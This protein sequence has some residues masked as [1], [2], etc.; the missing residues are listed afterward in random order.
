MEPSRRSATS[1]DRI[2]YYMDTLF[3]QK[4][5]QDDTL[6]ATTILSMLP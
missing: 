2:K 5:H 6:G 1:K 3:N 4:V